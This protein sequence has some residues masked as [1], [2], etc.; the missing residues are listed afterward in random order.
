[1]LTTVQQY[2]AMRDYVTL[3]ERAALLRALPPDA[4]GE[5]LPLMEQGECWGHCNKGA[6]MRTDLK[7]SVYLIRNSFLKKISF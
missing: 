1:M 6:A 5:I 2:V 3:G 7:L 4:G